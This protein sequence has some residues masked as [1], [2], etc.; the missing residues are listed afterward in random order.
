MADYTFDV[1]SGD[2]LADCLTA[3]PQISHWVRA[4]VTRLQVNRSHWS[5]ATVRVCAGGEVN[6][7]RVVYFAESASSK[8][9]IRRRH[10]LFKGFFD[11]VYH[12]AWFTDFRYRVGS[13]R[14]SLK[15]ARV[16]CS[17]KVVSVTYGA[18][19][20]EM[21]YRVLT[22]FRA[23]LTAVALLRSLPER[24][25]QA[26]YR[27]AVLLNS[28]LIAAN[29]CLPG[30]RDRVADLATAFRSP[31]S[32]VLHEA[33]TRILVHSEWHLEVLR[34]IWC[35]LDGWLRKAPGAFVMS[36]LDFTDSCPRMSD[37]CFDSTPLL[38]QFR[39]RLVESTESGPFSCPPTFDA[40]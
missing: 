23:L 21:E 3:F 37:D 29:V 39:H 28:D 2:G 18:F 20:R 31:F 33:V 10:F 30:F 34:Y 11:I 8:V 1:L 4:F 40:K 38:V 32:H 6:N 12:R 16:C 24:L 36:E 14:L 25:V 15:V 35:D 27:R 9:K 17:S 22:D 19:A 13:P 26:H 5:A 7:W